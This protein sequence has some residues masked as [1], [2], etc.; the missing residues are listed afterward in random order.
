MKLLVFMDD[1]NAGRSS[2]IAI[3]GVFFVTGAIVIF[4]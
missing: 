3:P 4:R 1:V 2:A